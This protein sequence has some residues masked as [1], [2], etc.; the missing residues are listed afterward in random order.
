MTIDFKGGTKLK[1]QCI[2][3]MYNL[4]VK[5]LMPK[6]QNKLYI[7]IEFVT[8]LKKNTGIDAVCAWED[9]N[10]RPRWFSIEVDNSLGLKELLIALAHELVH[11]KQYARNELKQLIKTNQLTWHSKVFDVSSTSYSN[12]PWEV[13][14]FEKEQQIFKEWYSNNQHRLK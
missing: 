14:A 13:E 5:M 3:D 11:V 7:E 10:H 12:Y 1:Q 9:T 2:T 8:G 4:G 6:L